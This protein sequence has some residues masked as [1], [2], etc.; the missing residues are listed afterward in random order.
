MNTPGIQTKKASDHTK[1]V[2]CPVCNSDSYHWVQLPTVSLFRCA[3]CS[4]CFTDISSIA[5][6]ETYGSEY[7]QE[8]HRNWFENPNYTLFAQ[9]ASEISFHKSK[10]VL[11]VGCGN[12]AFLKYLANGSGAL[13]L[14]GIDLAD[15]A[16]S[17]AGIEF[18]Q[19]DFLTYDFQKRFDAIVTLAVIE[20]LYD[21]SSFVRRIHELLNKN[22]IACVMTLSESGVLYRFANFLRKIGVQS[23]F[24]RL[25]DPH[26]I[27]HFSKES[28]EKLLTRDGLFR[29]RKIIDHNTPLAAIDVPASSSVMKL[30]MKLG[31]AVVFFVGKITKKAYL[32][33]IVVAKV[34]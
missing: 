15:E 19:G 26:H 32:Q 30:A 4:H 5:K 33:T 12:G 8:T 10:S 22:G 23:V 11:D 29:V 6:E 31:V 24:I 34:D 3:E 1:G 18:R 25:Y 7:Y 13:S 9:L 27:N 21:V 17:V 14:H 2:A 20:H 28:L 16:G